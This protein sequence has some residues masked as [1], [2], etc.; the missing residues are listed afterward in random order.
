M[1]GYLNGLLSLLCI[2]IVFAYGV[3]LPVTAGQLNLGGAG[4]QALG[5]YLAAYLNAT[6][7]VPPMYSLPL[8]AL[9]GGVAGLA[10]AFPVARVRG[11]Y[12]VLATIAFTQ[13]VSGAILASPALNG[14]AG[15][16]VPDFVGLNVIL[17]ITAAV[18]LLCFFLMSTRLGLAM[19][20]VHDDETVADLMGVSVRGIQV[21]CFT[22]GGCLAGL[23]GG[24]Y[25]HQFGFVQAQ[26]FD[27]ALSVEVLLFVLLGGGQTA[28]GPLVGASVF[29]LLPE[30]MRTFT[31]PVADFLAHLFGTKGPV[32]QPDE[33]W[34]FVVLGVFTVAMM[35]WRPQGIVTGPLVARI[36]GWFTP[37]A[38][39]R[40]ISG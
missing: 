17:P 39:R 15:I 11:V 32:A 37:R 19:R 33:S 24:L 28:W 9:I 22:I 35:I 13:V 6:Y 4:F 25:A 1:S 8:S 36:S 27:D 34:R 20:S 7:G 40:A 5:A 3:F 26:G 12:M 10:L 14:A 31:P 29:V 18:I 30:V 23:S 21:F 2:D 38:V 16:P